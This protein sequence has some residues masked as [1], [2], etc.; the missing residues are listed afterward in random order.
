[1]LLRFVLVLCTFGDTVVF[2]RLTRRL[3]V[4]GFVQGR[5]RVVLAQERVNLDRTVRANDMHP[6]GSL[7]Q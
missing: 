3:L 6:V 4:I 1:V 5:R 7:R 2:L